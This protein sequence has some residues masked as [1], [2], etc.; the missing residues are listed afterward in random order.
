MQVTMDLGAVFAQI[1]PDGTERRAF[2]SRTL[3]KKHWLVCEL[4]KNG[5]HICGDAASLSAQTTKH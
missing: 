1:Q 4:Q 2:A 3:K 5:E